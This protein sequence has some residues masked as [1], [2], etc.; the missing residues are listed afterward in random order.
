[1]G[2]IAPHDTAVKVVPAYMAV[3]RPPLI[4][5]LAARPMAH[6]QP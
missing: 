1:M 2:L 6:V 5:A 4:S 3:R